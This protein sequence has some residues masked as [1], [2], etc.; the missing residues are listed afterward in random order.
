M[1]GKS[2]KKNDRFYFLPVCKT[3]QNSTFHRDIFTMILKRRRMCQNGTFVRE[4]VKGAALYKF[5]HIVGYMML[6][7]PNGFQLAATSPAYMAEALALGE[8]AQAR[9]IDFVKAIGSSAVVCGT[10]VKVLR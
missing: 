2:A 9:T 8:Q 7:L 1:T 3:I 4:R 5:R 6:F 10:V